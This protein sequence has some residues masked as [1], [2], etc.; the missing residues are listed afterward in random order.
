MSL[1][2]GFTC[3][4]GTTYIFPPYMYAHWDIELEHHCLNCERTN[5]FREGILILSLIKENRNDPE[6]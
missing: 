5:Y 1:S 2:K 6:S 3:G 4:C